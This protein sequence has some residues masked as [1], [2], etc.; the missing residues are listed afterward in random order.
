[1]WQTSRRIPTGFPVFVLLRC[2]SLLTLFM[3]LS[4]SSY[5]KRKDDVVVMT[6]GDSFT[7]EI[8]SLK[9]GELEFK[10]EYMKDSVYLDWTQ[11]TLLQSKD[12]FIVALTDGR[13]L[14]AG[15]QTLNPEAGGEQQFQIVAEDQSIRAAPGAVIT[16]EQREVSF[17]NQLVGDVNYGFS[18]ASGNHST[19]SSLGA[20]VGFK[21]AVNSLKLATS[22]QFDS[23]KSA[24]NTNRFTF[25][26]EYDRTLTARWIASGLF[27]LLKS[28]QQDL[29]LRSTY[30]GGVGRRLVQTDR[31]TVLAIGGLAYSHEN[32]LPQP[33]T[34]PVRNN[35]EA[36]FGIRFSTFRFKTFRLDS[37]T[38]V[39]PSLTDA[40]RVR[41]SSQSS[42]RIE[43][44]RNFYWNG[45]VYE[46]YDT[47]P[48]VNAPKNDL[49]LT[50]S[51]GWTF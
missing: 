28:N 23:Q 5:A 22:S 31:T 46:N 14:I 16:M 26:S 1:L 51:L 20:D 19:N 33:G 30:G 29:N 10:A 48:P 49:G 7:G 24:P 38:F 21:G 25:D 11:V 15:I 47:R 45:Q 37:N 3:L 42:I 34:E 18:F 43:L 13:R 35:A 6:N 2:A 44:V 27:S 8:K 40:G 36:L 39:F 9:N 12:S 17:W 41:I 32:Y 4:L 50:T